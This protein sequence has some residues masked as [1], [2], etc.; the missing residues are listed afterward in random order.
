VTETSLYV[1]PDW[2]G[3]G[4]G[5]RFLL[6][7][8]ASSELHEIW[9]LYGSTFPENEESIRIQLSCGFRVVGR[10]ERIARHRGVWRDTV[11]T[12]RRSQVVGV[13]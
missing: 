3:L 8:I 1:A 2:R 7:L 6:A 11:I 10:R 4:I 5:R 13:G 9:S 12:E